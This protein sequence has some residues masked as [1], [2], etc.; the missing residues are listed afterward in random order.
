MIRELN[1]V[2]GAA[3][4]EAIARPPAT[5]RTVS[6]TVDT[7]SG[8]TFVASVMGR[9][10]N[11]PNPPSAILIGFTSALAATGS[12]EQ[13]VALL[14][15]A[16]ARLGAGLT[17]FEVMNRFSLDL[18]AQHF[19]ALPQPLPRSAWTVLLEQSDSE[20]EAH[21]RACFE[22]LKGH[23]LPIPQIRREKYVSSSNPNR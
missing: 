6:T 5:R 9:V 22:A 12:L 15:L 13:C 2:C 17:G 16:Q 21:A 19:P 18:V 3:K 1:G 8:R 4:G 10:A 14:G 11:L 23:G 7:V 20:G